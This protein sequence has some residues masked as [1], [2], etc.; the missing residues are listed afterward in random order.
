LAISSGIACKVSL[1]TNFVSVF[2]PRSIYGQFLNNTVD[3]CI[4][5]CL[6]RPQVTDVSTCTKWILKRAVSVHLQ[7]CHVLKLVGGHLQAIS[8]CSG[9][10][11]DEAMT[12][13]L[14]HSKTLSV[15]CYSV[16]GK[17]LHIMC[18]HTSSCVPTVVFYWNFTC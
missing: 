10:A 15:V 14:D 18:S 7:S 6:R 1:Q 12:L 4:A 16:V 9:K 13:I 11:C 3:V 2:C 5:A 8:S 17:P